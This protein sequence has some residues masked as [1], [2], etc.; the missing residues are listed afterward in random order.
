MQ[1]QS[2]PSRV[3][4]HD[5]RDGL[6]AVKSPFSAAT[7]I[8]TPKKETGSPDLDAIDAACDEGT[9]AIKALRAKVEAYRAQP[10]KET[11]I[12][13]AKAI[14]KRAWEIG[15]EDPSLTFE[16]AEAKAKEEAAKE[17]PAA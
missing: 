2:T 12:G 14:A 1:A 6:T 8:W 13:K 5:L 15:R 7:L 10:A 4:D 11:K 9:K 17:T 16:Q 3:T